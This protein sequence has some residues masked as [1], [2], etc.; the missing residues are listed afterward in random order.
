MKRFTCLLLF[1]SCCCAPGLSCAGQATN[2]ASLLKNAPS[3]RGVEYRCDSMVRTV[4][5]LRQLGKDQALDVIRHHLLENDKY[6]APDQWTKILIV[7]RL[8]FV[9]TNGWQPPR[10]GQP[11]PNVD[12]KVARQFPLFPIALSDGVPFL[13]VRDYNAGGFT[14]D[15]A[16]KCVKLCEGFPLISTDLPEQGLKDA[17]QNLVKSELF[18]GLYST[19]ES[20]EDANIMILEQAS[21]DPKPEAKEFR[22]TIE[23]NVNQH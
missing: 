2:A 19:P 16:D 17:A 23:V 4:N 22:S 18:Q 3:I 12:W 13:L 14:S 10:L 21:D 7:C 11:V 5:S 20:K 8:L 9:N 15:T 1:I 6:A